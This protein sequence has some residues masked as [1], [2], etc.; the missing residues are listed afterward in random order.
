MG[1]SPLIPLSS[2]S[3]E[4][5][6]EELTSSQLQRKGGRDLGTLAFPA[7]GCPYLRELGRGY[8][9]LVPRG[10]SITTR[11]RPIPKPPDRAV[12]GNQNPALS[13]FPL[14]GVDSWMLDT[15]RLPPHSWPS[16]PRPKPP[17][18]ALGLVKKAK[19]WQHLG[20][21]GPSRCGR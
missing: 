9:V 14:F 12:L 11:W 7:L 6:S 16:D 1:S 8:R 4:T 21:S 10:Q 13:Y 3:R 2:E 5:E 20:C 19:Q 15:P 17:T 18:G